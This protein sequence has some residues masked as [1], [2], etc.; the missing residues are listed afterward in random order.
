VSLISSTAPG[1]P[2]AYVLRREGVRGYGGTVPHIFN[3]SKRWRWS[4]GFTLQQHYFRG[5]QLPVHIWREVCWATELVWKV[6]NS[7]M[8]HRHPVHSQ[9]PW[10]IHVIPC[11]S[12]DYSGNQHQKHINAYATVCLFRRT[13]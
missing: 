3:V 12:H 11:N 9:S 8:E 2:C 10:A 5:K 6:V 7:E 4:V 1:T 13:F